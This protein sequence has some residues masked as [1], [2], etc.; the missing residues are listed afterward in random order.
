MN[1][2][3]GDYLHLEY[4]QN[5]LDLKVVAI[6]KQD[7]KFTEFENTLVLMNLVQ[8]QLFLD[9]QNQINFIYGT[10]ENPE[11]IYDVRNTALTNY[12]R[13]SIKEHRNSQFC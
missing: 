13:D 11:S 6:C 9:K 3:L 10:I 2:T 4:I 7:L 8:V 12:I 5:Q 1:L